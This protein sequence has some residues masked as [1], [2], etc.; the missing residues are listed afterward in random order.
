MIF[1]S[2]RIQDLKHKSHILRKQRSSEVLVVMD[3]HHN[4]SQHRAPNL[5]HLLQKKL[6]LG[7]QYQATP[8]KKMRMR[9]R[10]MMKKKKRI[11]IDMEQTFTNPL[12]I[13]ME[14]S[15]IKGLI[16]TILSDQENL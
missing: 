9:R 11:H 5:V 13:P 12:I 2:K 10:M 4:I 16:I 8:M 15:L 7:Q 1:V 6:Q 14:I 3:P